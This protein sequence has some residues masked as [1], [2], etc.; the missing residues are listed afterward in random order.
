MAKA[1]ARPSGT[2]ARRR[3]GTTE[4]GKGRRS[5]TTATLPPVSLRP[6]ISFVTLIVRDVA[7]SRRFYELLGLVA[8]ERSR[9]DLALFQMNGV[10]LALASR[11]AMDREL[12][13]A[14]STMRWPSGG[15]MLSQNVR[16]AGEVAGLLARARRAGA[17]VL[18]RDSSAPWGG[19]FGWFEDPDGHRWE[20]VFNERMVLDAKGNAWL[21]PPGVW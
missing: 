3:R 10:V 18:R 5:A 14:S 17:R 9:E 21:E 15:V 19:V 6:A 12:G 4:P 2:A 16:S 20:V 7:R 11:A 8:S 1:K 13:S